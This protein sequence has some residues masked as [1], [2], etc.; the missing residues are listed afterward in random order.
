M[1]LVFDNKNV[2][3]IQNLQ[4]DLFKIYKQ[5]NKNIEFIQN[6]QRV[7]SASSSRKHLRKSSIKDIFAENL[8]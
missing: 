5:D 7:H 1:T 6:L 2:E 4:W 3:F 8:E